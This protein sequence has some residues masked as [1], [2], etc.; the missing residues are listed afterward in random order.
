VITTVDAF[1]NLPNISQ[2]TKMLLEPVADPRWFVL[3]KTGQLVVFDP[4]NATSVSTYIDLSGVVRTASEGGL[5]GLAF[6]PDYPATPEIF[7]SYTRNHTGPPMR[8]VISR[9]ILDNVTTPG[10]G[11]VEQVILEVDQDF[12][13][14]NG[15]DIAFGADDL[16][17]IGFGDGG[18]GGDPNNRAQD[19]SRLLGS[20]LRIDV[21][22]PGVSHPTNPYNIPAGNPFAGNAEC[23]PGANAND[24]PEIYAWGMRNPWR[25]SFDPPTGDL[26]VGD[27][28]QVT[29]EE[30]DIVELG[31]NYGWR[32]REGAHDYNTSGCSGTGYMDPV[33]EY[34]RTEGNSITGGFVYRGSAVPGL[35]G[36]Y[37]FA[38]YGSGR[39]W[40]L[41]ADGQGG[42]TREELV[43]TSTGP[44]SF[45]VDAAGELYFTDINNSRL[46]RIVDAGGGGSDPIPDLLSDTGCVSPAD[47]TQPYA[48]LIPYDIN[49]PFW[50]DEAAKDRYI[51]LPNGT[52]IAVGSDGDWQFPAGTVIVKNFR[53]NGELIETRH[54][55]R[56]PDGDWAGY[57]YEWNDAQTEATLVQGGKV[58]DIGTQDWIFPSEAQCMQ[59]HTNAAGFALGPETAQLNRDFTYPQT[60]RTA[61]QLDTLDHIAVFASPLPGSPPSMADPADVS[62]DLNDRA[63]AYLHSNC[64]QCHRPNGPT[65][66]DIDFRYTTSLTDTNA[67]DAQPQAGDL[68]IINARIIA[69]G[70]ATR[71]VLV[72]RMQRRDTFGM[73]PI[74]SDITR[75]KAAA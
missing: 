53:V 12:D 22:G 39:F 21:L 32:C 58:A 42:Y 10:A 16:L 66:V 52:T 65:P 28:G 74:G 56:H 47:V 49:A 18:S 31:G 71:S 60:A 38:D 35:A 48:G 68:G 8:S 6:H 55:M 23:G 40:S 34:G 50:S 3:R 72:D 20:F 44:T 25:W 11:T 43:D 30:V 63:R 4:D 54:L 27:V 67:C 45:A 37:V 51:G 17:Y 73:P 7:L 13:N 61:N 29:W 57:T 5:L 69:P 64:S 14:H 75:R 33:A 15:G 62:A 46:R 26:W 19:T 1:P 70:D 36:R 9:F 2:P 24:C 41:A 59:C